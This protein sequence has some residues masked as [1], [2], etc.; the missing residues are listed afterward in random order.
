GSSCPMASAWSR[1]SVR[2]RSSARLRSSGS[3]PTKQAGSDEPSSAPGPVPGSARDVFP[4]TASQRSDHVRAW[5]RSSPGCPSCTAR[6]SPLGGHSRRCGTAVDPS[7]CGVCSPHRRDA[8]RDR[9]AVAEAFAHDHWAE[10]E[11]TLVAEG[12]IVEAEGAH[13]FALMTLRAYRAEI[14]DPEPKP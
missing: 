5:P 13:Q 6:V 14:D 1:W 2:S 9:L 8:Q 4:G 3:C 7:C 11:Q 10:E 12:K